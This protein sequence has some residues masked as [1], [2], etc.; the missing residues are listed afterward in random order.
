M[1]LSNVQDHPALTVPELLYRG[2]AP[3]AFQV[4]GYFQRLAGASARE[5]DA[6][7]GYLPAASS[8]LLWFHGAS[9]GEMAAAIRM[10]ALLE[11]NGFQFNAGFTASNRAGVEFC[12]Q[13]GRTLAALAPWDVTRWLRRAYDSWRPSALFLVETELWPGLIMTASERGV[14]VFCVS[15]RIYPRDLP[16]YRII[17]R[18]IQPSLQRVTV[19]LAQN[20]TER[21]R[22]IEIGAPSE[23]CVAAGNLKYLEMKSSGGAAKAHAR[24][25]LQPDR[26]TAVF[27]SVHED[28]VGFVFSALDQMRLDGLQIVIAPRHLSTT[29]TLVEQ[30]KRRDLRVRKRSDGNAGDAFD[31]LVLDSIG[32]L[33]C[34]YSVASVATVGGGF[35]PHGGHNPFEPLLEGVPVVIGR[36]FEH[37]S[38]EAQALNAAWP[39][40]SVEDPRQ[41]AETLGRWLRDEVERQRIMKMQQG[42]LPDRDGIAKRYL[43]ILTPWLEKCL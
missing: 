30:T 21:T 35:S 25:G 26:P 32:E 38:A 16:R 3:A 28:E 6:R 10:A 18:F 39:G 41:L 5:L 43:E 2:L 17:R 22:F 36:H 8:P 40:S 29:T 19:V 33:S 7:H 42:A 1:R 27:G 13:A 15:A 34:A 37:F 4:A 23:R 9:A 12:A 14:P 11:E 31:V 20:E 24:L